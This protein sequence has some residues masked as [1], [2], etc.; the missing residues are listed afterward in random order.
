MKFSV[1]AADP[2]DGDS[3]AAL[4]AENHR[5]FLAF[6]VKRVPTREIAEDVLQDAFVRGLA[7][8]P[9]QATSESA[10]AW[11][12]RVL[13]NAVIDYYRHAGV[14]KR[15]IERYA[16]EADDS[17]APVDPELMDTVCDCVRSLVGTLKPAYAAAIT[18]V[19]LDGVSPSAFAAEAGITS[20][21]ASVRLHRAHRALRDRVLE[22]C[23]TCADH[24]CRPCSCGSSPRA[25]AGPPSAPSRR[26][27]KDSPAPSS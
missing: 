23:A 11:F 2:I 19:D 26:H 8:A 13:H 9:T 12:Y 24:G 14:E 15:A 5:R 1:T 21:N 27:C 3:T 7:K 6:L 25:A 22:V 17:V 20:T 4:L 16:A 18:R 10:V